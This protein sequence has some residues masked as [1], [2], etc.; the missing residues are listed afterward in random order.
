MNDLLENVPEMSPFDRH[1]AVCLVW[2]GVSICLTVFA[3]T[4]LRQS[5][6]VTRARQTHK[7]AS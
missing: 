4:K 2:L 6:V 3:Y 7:K 5:Y 1:T